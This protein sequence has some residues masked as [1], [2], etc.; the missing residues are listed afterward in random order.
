MLTR[1]LQP[2]RWR[3]AHCAPW[4]LNQHL[5]GIHPRRPTLSPPAATTSPTI[6]ST[7]SA[8]ASSSSSP[9]LFSTKAIIGG[10]IDSV[11]DIALGAAAVFFF[12]YLPSKRK[13]GEVPAGGKLPLQSTDV[14]P[15]ESCR[16]EEKED[17]RRIHEAD[18]GAL[19]RGSR[20]GKSRDSTN[21][22]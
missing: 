9:S 11:G 20:W 8:A 18:A 4:G 19:A 5:S 7:Q 17:G 6:S 12:V 10:F 22:T 3:H 16:Q 13:Q 15:T 14:P 2:L 21:S 1:L